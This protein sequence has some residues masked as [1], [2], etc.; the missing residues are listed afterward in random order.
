MPVL[1]ALPSVIHPCLRQWL[2]HRQYLT[3]CVVLL[4]HPT[5][6]SGSSDDWKRRMRNAQHV[7]I[8]RREEAGL[9]F[10]SVK[11]ISYSFQQHAPHNLGQIFH[12]FVSQL[13]LSTPHCT[14]HLNTS[15]LC[16]A[17]ARCL[18]HLW[19]DNHDVVIKFHPHDTIRLV[20]AHAS[21]GCRFCDFMALFLRLNHRDFD[22]YNDVPLQLFIPPAKS[23]GSYRWIHLNWRPNRAWEQIR[24]P[25]ITEGQ[26]YML[27]QVCHPFGETGA[28]Y[29]RFLSCLIIKD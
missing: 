22:Q 26:K 6:D 28:Y 20:K 29:A 3:G 7:G 19:K 24:I 27:T 12:R 2:R 13:E 15:Q 18:D 14:M 10:P 1:C 23:W 9:T 17:C 16:K 11:S 8:S 5:S 25:G 4:S 21:L